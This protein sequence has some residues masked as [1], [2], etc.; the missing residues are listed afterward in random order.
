MSMST[1]LETVMTPYGCMHNVHVLS[2]WDNGALILKDFWSYKVHV[3]RD[4]RNGDITTSIEGKTRKRLA[5]LM[6]LV[7]I[8]NS[9]WSSNASPTASVVV[10]ILMNREALSGIWLTTSRAMRIFAS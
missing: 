10:P 4:N 3:T 6:L 5:T 9:L 7:M 1:T 8:I 2:R